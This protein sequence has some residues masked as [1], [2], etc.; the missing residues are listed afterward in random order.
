M[1]IVKGIFGLKYF[2]DISLLGGMNWDEDV[3]W[4]AGKYV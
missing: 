1:Q 4:S 3:R 2:V